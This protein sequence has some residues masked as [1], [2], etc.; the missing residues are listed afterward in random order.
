[1]R[2]LQ[3]FL[4][5]VLCLTACQFPGDRET[6][7]PTAERVP[8]F[9]DDSL[10]MAQMT[11]AVSEAMDE[12]SP[13]SMSQLIATLQT[14][15]TAKVALP[16]TAQGTLSEVQESIT[17]VGGVYQCNRCTRWH[18][19][20]SSGFLIADDLL[21][22]NYHVVN[23]PSHQAMA[24]RLFDGRVLMVKEVVAANRENDLVVLRIPSTGL[25]PIA[26]G[27]AAPVGAQV[28]LISHPK[29]RFYTLSEGRISR[30][31]IRRQGERQTPM[32][33]I[34]ADFGRGSSGAPV[35]NKKGQVVGIATSTESAY[36]SEEDGQQKNLQM[37]FKHCIPVQQ[38]R[39]LIGG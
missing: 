27:A 3:G 10:I 29:R 8:A 1:M 14:E 30:Y 9:L 28:D 38:L 4:G 25:K 37:V 22:T 24:V 31:F 33:S 21:V 36:Y 23:Q 16:K 7:M 19:A 35:L 5:L 32:M 34:T 13:V 18:V 39:K 2:L 20:P 11:Q 15:P 17:I 26:L 12:A 6:H